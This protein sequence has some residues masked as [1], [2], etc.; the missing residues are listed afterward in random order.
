[1]LF[2][3][4]FYYY[5]NVQLPNAG[6]V[7]R[8]IGSVWTN[9]SNGVAVLTDADTVLQTVTCSCDP[10]EKAVNPSGTL[11]PSGSYYDQMVVQDVPLDYQIRF[12]NTGT[13]TAYAVIIRD[14]ID[15]SLDL[16]T[17]EIQGGSHPFTTQLGNDRVLTFTF[18]GI[19]LP[20][21]NVNE[22]ASH[23]F[24]QYRIRP[25]CQPACDI[26]NTAYKIGRAHV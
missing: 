21:S 4:H 18:D 10:N 8:T 16:S 9:D 7:V 22:P 11:F 1:M 20:D 25:L 23:G 24:V 2:R 3:S 15:H 12:Q 19:Y 6:A 13:D 5:L 17:L 14:T 26:F